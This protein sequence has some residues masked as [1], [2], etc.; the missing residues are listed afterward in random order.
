MKHIIQMTNM[1]TS[2]LFT[3][4]QQSE[5]I[6]SKSRPKCRVPW[7]LQVN[8]EKRDKMKIYEKCAQLKNMLGFRS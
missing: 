7:K 8:R 5:F 2:S 3:L 4:K 1:K 6:P